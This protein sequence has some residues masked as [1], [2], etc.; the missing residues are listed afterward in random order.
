MA[1]FAIYPGSS[2]YPLLELAVAFGANWSA[3]APTWTPLT[4]KMRVAEGIKIKRGGSDDVLPKTE[5]ATLDFTLDNRTRDFDPSYSSGAYYPNLVP[6]TQVRL[7]AYWPTSGTSYTLFYG[8]IEDWFPTWTPGGEAITQVSAVDRLGMLAFLRASGSFV[9][10]TSGV[11]LSTIAS[12]AS[13]P[14]SWYSFGTGGTSLQAVQGAGGIALDMMTQLAELS[15]SF[16][17]CDRAGVIRIKGASGGA[18]VATFGDGGGSELPYRPQF[19]AQVD[20]ARWYTQAQIN[21]EGGTGATQVTSAADVTRYGT[22]TYS[23]SVPFC[24]A[25][26]AAG[27]ATSLASF[28]NG[29]QKLRVKQAEVQ[30]AASPSALW[31]V[32]LPLE[33]GDTFTWKVR[34]SVGAAFSQD[35]WVAGLEHEIGQG[36]WLTRLQLAAT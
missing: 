4:D 29:Q 17:Y 34:P 15:N 20:G 6:A 13:L 30:G 23:R 3:T 27:L 31:P 33:L 9:A 7:T 22:R 14:A 25:T 28:L 19:D 2:R 16:L 24:D 36:S 12:R 18:V 21:V 26:T 10:S 8:F 11:R 1:A 35:A 32:L 5:V